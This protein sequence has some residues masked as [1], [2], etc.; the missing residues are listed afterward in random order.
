MLNEIFE[1]DKDVNNKKM[2]MF[3]QEKDIKFST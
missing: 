2:K 1:L 3:A